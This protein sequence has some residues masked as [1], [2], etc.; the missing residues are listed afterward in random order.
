M[1][2]IFDSN[3]F[4]VISHYFPER[5]PSFWK[6][7]DEY[8]S[9]GKILSVREVFNEL[10]NNS[11]K[12]HLIDW[13]KTNKS[14]FMIPSQPEMNFVNSIFQVPHF[15]YLVSTKQ[16][17]K[18]SPVADPFVIASAKV[19][20]GCVVTEENKKK[21]SSRIPNICDHF[22]IDCT[23]IEGFMRRENWEF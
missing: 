2:Y 11:S 19:K 16:R 23:N 9:D 21:N 22:N 18:G 14:I 17:L 10:D 7:I 4:I 6:Q 12:I 13:L 20:N 8:V 15:Q 5:F 1:V 3:S